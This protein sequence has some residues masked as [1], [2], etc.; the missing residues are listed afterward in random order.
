VTS[1]TLRRPPIRAVGRACFGTEAQP[2]LAG[3]PLSD[4]KTTW[5]QLYWQQGT[6]FSRWQFHHDHVSCP[7]IAAVDDNRHYAGLADEVTFR[8]PPEY[9]R[10]QTPLECVNLPAGIAQTG[11]LDHSTEPEP[12]QRPLWQTKQIDAARPR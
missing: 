10:C 11:N 7:Y 6:L 4:H 1:T 12:Q 5:V 2:D 8:V 9:C 3:A